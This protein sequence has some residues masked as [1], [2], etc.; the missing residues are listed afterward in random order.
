VWQ[1]QTP[2]G[3]LE[4]RIEPQNIK[5]VAVFVTAGDGE[6]PRMRSRSRRR[7]AKPKR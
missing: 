4:R 1:A 6:R 5:V 3:Q 7:F 2:A